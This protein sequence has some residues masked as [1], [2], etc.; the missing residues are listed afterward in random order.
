[1]GSNK[2]WIGGKWVD[3]ESGQTFAVLN[4]STEE[5]LGRAPLGGQSDIDK[6]VKAAAGLAP[7]S[8]RK[9]RSARRASVI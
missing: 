9:K 1:M 8:L 7:K 5:E 2:M 3:A 4:P 6:A